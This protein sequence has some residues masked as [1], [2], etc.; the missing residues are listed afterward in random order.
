M[1]NSVEKDSYNNR[2]KS[3][4]KYGHFL[5]KIYSINNNK[6]GKENI[7][8][9]NKIIPNRRLIPIGKKLI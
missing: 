5:P 6:K 9:E 3:K 4:N 7:Y 2:Y 1:P 8:E